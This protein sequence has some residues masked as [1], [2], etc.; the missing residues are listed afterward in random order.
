MLEII[1]AERDKRYELSTKY[2]R[3]VN[4]IDVIDTWLAITAIGLGITEVGLLSA[5]VA[6]S[7]VVGMEAVS[8]VMGYL[9]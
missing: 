8:S 9:Q 7:A 5:I 3:W 4:T 2:N 1:I 6:T